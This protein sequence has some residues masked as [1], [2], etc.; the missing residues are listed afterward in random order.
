MANFFDTN[1]LI[2]AVG[3]IPS[4]S[5][6]A[7]DLVE[8]GGVIS[9]QVLNEFV[10]V[11]RRKLR[12]DFSAIEIALEHFKEFLEVVPVS[13][14]TQLS[15]LA[16]AQTTNIDI[17]DCNIVAAADLSGC[18]TLLSEDMQDGQRVRNVRIQ[19]PFRGE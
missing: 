14:D 4:K 17:F 11:C 9:T 2:Y 18:S 19:N 16:I 5:N 15:A 12:L 6:R 13:L 3:Q 1:V 10:H 8:S 7:I